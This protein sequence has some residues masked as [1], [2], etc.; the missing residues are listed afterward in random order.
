MHFFQTTNHHLLEPKPT[1]SLTEDQKALILSNSEDKLNESSKTDEENPRLRSFAFLG[2]RSDFMKE[3][4]TDIPLSE[5]SSPQLEAQEAFLIKNIDTGESY[6]LRNLKTL[7]EINSKFRLLDENNKNT[8]WKSYW[9][10]VNHRIEQLW[11]AAEM[12]DL[13]KLK[14]ILLINENAYTLDINVKGLDKWTALH[15]ACN[16]GHTAL[17]EFLLSQGADIESKTKMERRSLHI[18]AI[19]GHIE[20]VGILIKNGCQLEPE[21]EDLYTPLHYASEHGF[22]DIVREL[23]NHDVR[24]DLKNY[25]GMTAMDLSQDYCIMEIFKEY[26]KEVNFGRTSYGN[27]IRTTSRADYVNKLLFTGNRIK[28]K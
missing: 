9:K 12:G 5:C 14:S 16:E 6:D 21:D 3:F 2:L 19:R 7:E 4:L 13:A 28:I 25:Q 24:I 10:E 26:N 8:A 22:D 17:V 27:C 18:A 11:D 20:V 1:E 23:L 15:H